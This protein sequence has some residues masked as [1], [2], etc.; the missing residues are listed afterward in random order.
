MPYVEDRELNKTK[1]WLGMSIVSAF[2]DLS[3]EDDH[4]AGARMGN[5]T[6][7]RQAWAAECSSVQG[8]DAA[9]PEQKIQSK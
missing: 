4:E 5:M 1:P 6:S 9:F 2:G 8:S 7:S 3:Q